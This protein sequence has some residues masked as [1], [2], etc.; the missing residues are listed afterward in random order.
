MAVLV[1]SAVDLRQCPKI[2]VRHGRG[3]RRREFERRRVPM[4]VRSFLPFLYAD[5]KIYDERDLEYKQQ[6]RGDRHHLV[7]LHD[8][9]CEFVGLAAVVEAPRNARHPLDEHGEEDGIHADDRSP[10]M[11]LSEGL[12][13]RAAGDL[14]EPVVDPAQQRQYRSGRHDV[15]EVADHVVGIVKRYVRRRQAERKAG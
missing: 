13:H 5:R 10:E 7:P 2:S 6:P 8:A 12:V 4:V 14:G 9:L 1:R 11:Y 15:V 3:R